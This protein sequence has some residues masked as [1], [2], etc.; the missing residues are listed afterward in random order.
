MAESR[1]PGRSGL[2]SVIPRF[3]LL[4]GKAFSAGGNSLAVRP[5]L[6][7]AFRLGWMHKQRGLINPPTA[8]RGGQQ[9]RPSPTL[10]QIPP[11]RITMFHLARAACPSV[12]FAFRRTPPRN[13]Y[14]LPN[15]SLFEEPSSVTPSGL[16]IVPVLCLPFDQNAYLVWL[17]DL[18][19]CVVVDP[20][21]EPQK[22][23]DAL[24]ERGLHPAAI[25]NTHGHIDH[26]GGNAAL[27]DRWPDCPVVIGAGDA[28][29]LT[30]PERN[31]SAP[32][33]LPLAGP[34]ADAT[35][36]DGDLYQAAGIGWRVLSIPGHT[37]G[38]VVYVA[39]G[40]EPAAVFV[41]DVIMAGSVGRTD[42][43]GGSHEQLI[44]GIRSKLFT[45]P[46]DT[47]LLPGH[48][49]TTT[50]GEEKRT[51]PFAGLRAR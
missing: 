37:P 43:P 29:M 48:G 35:V 15:P 16:Q 32:F 24:D 41:G 10:S 34:A 18:K 3:D 26:I 28:A 38:H 4:F 11:L 21:L 44:A 49:P 36:D 39:E 25:L 46:D 14:I 51:N 50:V 27:K 31:L 7:K 20:G 12:R 47:L 19:D 45:L 40:H 2:R 33:G 8:E 42:F 9:F 13:R 30:D 1:D 6:G 22:I 5:A 17:Q 23:L